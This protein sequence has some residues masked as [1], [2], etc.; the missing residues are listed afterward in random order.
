VPETLTPEKQAEMQRTQTVQE[1][2]DY[3]D[4][5]DLHRRSPSDYAGPDRCRTCHQEPHPRNLM[6]EH[7]YAPPQ[8]LAYPIYERCLSC[9]ATGFDQPGG[10]L[11]PAERPDLLGVACESCHGP[12]ATHALAGGY[13]APPKP[14]SSACGE[15]HDTVKRPGE[16]P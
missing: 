14:D 3:Y 7:R 5:Q 15:C 12:Q 8:V 13:P 16:H 10:F 2:S 4:L 9:H 1:L 6:E 11:E